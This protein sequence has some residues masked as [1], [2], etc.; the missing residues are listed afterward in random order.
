MWISPPVLGNKCYMSQNDKK[1]VHILTHHKIKSMTLLLK[2]YCSTFCMHMATKLHHFHQYAGVVKISKFA[3][4]IAR[5]YWLWVYH[6]ILSIDNIFGHT[7]NI[8]SIHL[9]SCTYMSSQGG[10]LWLASSFC[11]DPHSS[12]VVL[13]VSLCHFQRDLCQNWNY[14]SKILE[15]K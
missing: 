2:L 14:K 8:G 9:Q 12:N 5:F 3:T 1:I 7:I 4:S 15:S 6:R 11:Y 13:R 10:V